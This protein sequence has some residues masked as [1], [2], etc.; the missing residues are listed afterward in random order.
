[1]STRPTVMA[2]NEARIIN[3]LPSYP[4][5]TGHHLSDRTYTPFTTR[6]P[7]GDAVIEYQENIRNYQRAYQANLEYSRRQGLRTAQEVPPAVHNTFLNKIK[8]FMKRFSRK[9]NRRN[10]VAPDPIFTMGAPPVFARY[11]PKGRKSRKKRKKTRRKSKKNK[12][13]TIKK[14]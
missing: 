9:R 10:R 2:I 14:R 11:S 5:F 4:V 3:D 12:R 7:Y 13:K 6:S 1:M 8:N